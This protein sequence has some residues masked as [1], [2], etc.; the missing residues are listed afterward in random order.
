[1]FGS[2]KPRGGCNNNNSEAAK[3]FVLT[4]DDDHVLSEIEE[5]LTAFLDRHKVFR[6]LQN[7]KTLPC[8]MKTASLTR[9][10]RTP[11]L[12]P[13]LKAVPPTP[14]PR[15]RSSSRSRALGSTDIPSCWS[16]SPSPS[17]AASPSLSLGR[18]R[19]PQGLHELMVIKLKV[20]ICPA[21]LF[22]L[23]RFYDCFRTK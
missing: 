10:E 5:E 9:C 12:P 22:R 16:A 18:S 1:M 17:S 14:P 7:G 13:K 8:W 19:K 6:G 20:L 2:W 15:R 4:A 11:P 3:P 23:C 21:L